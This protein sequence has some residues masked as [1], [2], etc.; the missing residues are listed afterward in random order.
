MKKAGIAI[1]F[2][3]IAAFVLSGCVKKVSR[4]GKTE[5]AQYFPLNDGDIRIYSGSLGK[6]VV[7][8]RI[9]NLCTM[10]FYDTTGRINWWQDYLK[11][12]TGAQMK[13]VVFN[14][15]GMPAAYFEPAIPFTPWSVTV[16]DTMLVTAAEIRGDSV[17]THVRVMIQFQIMA[18]EP[19]TTPAGAFEDCIEMR[20][21]YK[22][23][24]NSIPSIFDGDSFWWFARDIG[25][26]KYESPGDRGE[27]LK[28]RI[29]MVNYP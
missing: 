10:T 27:L 18:I 8:G 3:F 23:R 22:T 15:A 20:M 13:N 19:V 4:P 24:D 2:L 14:S 7:K 1:I 16:G 21:S 9:G 5:F 12:E 17:N 28:A 25:L 11:S 29:N 6:A 26:V